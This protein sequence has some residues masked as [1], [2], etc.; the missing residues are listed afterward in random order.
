MTSINERIGSVVRRHRE[1]RG[2]SQEGL[3]ALAEMSRA[4]VGELERGEV[5][6]SIA[7]L[8]KIASALGEKLSDLIIEYENHPSA[9]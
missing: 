6:P 4:H 2:L 7:T 1:L 5:T 8:Q 3:A 9:T